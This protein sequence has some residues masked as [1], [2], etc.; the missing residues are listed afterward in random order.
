MNLI[1]TYPLLLLVSLLGTSS[2]LAQQ[3]TKTRAT[4]TYRIYLVYTP[5]G[6]FRRLLHP[7]LP[8]LPAKPW[9]YAATKVPAGA[10]PG[11]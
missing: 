5:A 8:K 3:E 4:A 7:S 9:N 10:L 1:K 2:A 11:K 6:K